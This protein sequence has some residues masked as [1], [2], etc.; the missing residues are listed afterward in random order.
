MDQT[1]PAWKLS[2]KIA[3][4]MV[5]R[6]LKNIK[7]GTIKVSDD[8]GTYLFGQQKED[9][10]LVATITIHNP[11]AYQSILLDGSV[12]AGTSYVDGAWSTND[13]Q[14]L[15][16]LVIKNDS[17]FYQIEGPIA[18]L[19]SALRTIL[20]KL[21]TNSIHR[22]KENILAHYDL[23]NDFFKLILD[24]TMMYSC[25]L[26]KPQGITLEEASTKKIQAICDALQLQPSDHLLE[27]GTGWGGF[28]CYAAKKYGCKVTTTTISDKQYLYVKEKIDQLGLSDQI[29]LLK[30]DYRNLSGQYDKI[31]SIE[32]IEAV[33]HQ[34]FD[35]F[36]HQCDQ[37][38]KPEGLFFLQ[39]IVINDQAYEA[40]KNKV[41]Y[42]KKYIFPGGCLPSVQS[43][44][45][46][47]ARQTTMQLM[48]FEDIGQH[49]FFTLND[50]YKK[51][52]ANQADII[53][54]GFNESFIRMWEFYF[55][56]CAA[57]FRTHYISDI[58]GLWRK[59]K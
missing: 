30:E 45:D 26:Y 15:I 24:P 6:L 57:G 33:G 16:T 53:A 35:A 22:A 47:I 56:Y 8:S 37:L 9:P 14:K 40:A 39:A 59:R 49:Y 32:M 48:S 4:K 11:K 3:K 54:Q 20:Y 42:I 34:Y 36:F 31:V 19:F 17:L 1:K 41:D 29:E 28:A 43:I 44:S 2:E 25:A 7:K 10:E 58:H 46:S 51:L 18:R 23:G 12:G 38:L 52:L 21:K 13:L 55:C 50:W 27:I 5:F